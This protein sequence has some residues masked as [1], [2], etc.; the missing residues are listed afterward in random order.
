MILQ[1]KNN[2]VVET[3]A[4]KR[5][6]NLCN[7]LVLKFIK[8]LLTTGQAGKSEKNKVKFWQTWLGSKQYLCRKIVS[9]ILLTNQF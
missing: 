7:K 9:K 5:D 6:S 4:T 8:W 1:K 2:F 3:E